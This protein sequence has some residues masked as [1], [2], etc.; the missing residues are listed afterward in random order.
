MK[1][2]EEVIWTVLLV[3]CTISCGGPEELAT[4][5]EISLDSPEVS[6]EAGQVFVR[7]ASNSSWTI[8]I[9]GGADWAD[10]SPASGSGNKNSIILRYGFNDSV[11][12]RTLEVS[13]ASGDVVKTVLLTQKGRAVVTTEGG[14]SSSAPYKWLELPATDPKDKFDFLYHT[15]EQKGRTI[16]NYS[17]Y[18]DF[19]N[20]VA[21]WVAY[22]LNSDLIGHGGRS[23][24]WGMEPLLS[25]S[26]QPVLYSAFREG[27]YGWYARGHQCPSADRLDYDSNVQTFYG[28]NMTPQ[29]NDFNGKIWA[30][31]EQKVRNWANS[32]D[33]LYV[34]TGCSVD[35]AKYFVYDNQGK[36]VTVPTGY[37][38]AVLRYSTTSSL[39]HKG[40][41]GFAIYLEHKVY[42]QNNIS[43]SMSMS[44]DD[45]E[46]KLGTDLFV[47]LPDVVGKS[48]ADTIESEDPSKISWWW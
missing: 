39:G 35:G 43:K 38:K 36:K 44:I 4:T 1:R 25:S 48:T 18:W 34:V 17:Y 41:M 16:R 9:G 6:A 32:S 14:R 23:D 19:D 5:L 7:I 11:D 24:Q 12:P 26:E 3:L 40:Y 2:L 10:V 28:T 30:S 20:M 47:N 45:L 31:L 22:P 37:F 27:N 8:S 33:T 15:F 42:S 21:H 46:K 29:D 13:A